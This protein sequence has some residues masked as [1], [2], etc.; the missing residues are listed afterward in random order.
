M[1]KNFL[2]ALTVLMFLDYLWSGVVMHSYYAELLRPISQSEENQLI[3]NWPAILISYGLLAVGLAA[4]VLDKP[5]LK[6]P[7]YGL[8]GALFGLV[9][10]G[11][12]NLNSYATLRDW[13]TILIFI[14]VAWG[15][16]VCATACL[17]VAFI[18]KP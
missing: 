3:H 11:V 12:Y 13:P 16:V 10:Y 18:A 2:V 7:H 8:R 15:M 9:V 5:A 17:V 4:L 1:L 14:D 6:L